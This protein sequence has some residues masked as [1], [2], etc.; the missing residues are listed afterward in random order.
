ME[1]N[2]FSKD[3]L[4]RFVTPS[5]LEEIPKIPHLLLSACPESVGACLQATGQPG[6]IFGLRIP[7]DLEGNGYLEPANSEIVEDFGLWVEERN[8]AMVRNLGAFGSICSFTMVINAYTDLNLLRKLYAGA[9]PDHGFYEGT[10]LPLALK[11]R[12][13]LQWAYIP[14]IAEESG[15]AMFVVTDS[16]KEI[17]MELEKRVGLRGLEYAKMKFDLFFKVSLLFMVLMFAGCADF[18]HEEGTFVGEGTLIT[19]N[20][21]NGKPV[22]AIELKIDRGQVKDPIVSTSPV[23]VD[24]KDKLIN[25]EKFANRKLKVYG[26]IIDRSAYNPANGNK[27]ARSDPNFNSYVDVIETKASKIIDLGPAERSDSRK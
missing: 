25:S 2:I 18:P 6:G 4:K 5:A 26:K 13:E 7:Y 22:K 11:L 24:S 20:E 3:Y 19:L 1:I 9:E 8:Q 16:K 17:L 15:V 10:F 23:L 14:L 27:V 21:R 12:N